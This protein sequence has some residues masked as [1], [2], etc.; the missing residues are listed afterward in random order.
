MLPVFPPLQA[1]LVCEAMEALKTVG[2]V[3]IA[4]VEAV[5]PFASVTVIV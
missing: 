2:S 5:Q 3:M 1:T 4:D